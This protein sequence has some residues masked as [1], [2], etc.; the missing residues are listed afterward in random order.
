MGG[1]ACN[2]HVVRGS[3][4]NPGDLPELTVLEG[5]LLN[6]R[7]RDYPCATPSSPTIAVSRWLC[8]SPIPSVIR[9]PWVGLPRRF[10]LLPSLTLLSCSSSSAFVQAEATAAPAHR[11]CSVLRRIVTTARRA[12]PFKSDRPVARQRRDPRWRCSAEALLRAGQA[13]SRWPAPNPGHRPAAGG[14]LRGRGT[15]AH[16]TPPMPSGT[17]EPSQAGAPQARPSPSLGDP[18]GGIVLPASTPAAVSSLFRAPAGNWR[19]FAN[20]GDWAWKSGCGRRSGVRPRP[21]FLPAKG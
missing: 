17:S 20:E 11:A 8:E 3:E 15:R 9:P 7:P 10:S 18:G 14:G 5:T 2:S 13:G 1:G 4:P 6:C 12:G 21:C 16:W 19:A